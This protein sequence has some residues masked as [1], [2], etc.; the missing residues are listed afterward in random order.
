ME[1]NNVEFGIL[2][3]SE[4]FDNAADG[5][6]YKE[7][8]EYS[9]VLDVIELDRSRDADDEDEEDDNINHHDPVGYDELL[10]AIRAVVW[11][12]V[13]LKR[14][15]NGN[16]LRQLQNGNDIDRVANGAPAEVATASGP[17][18]SS[19]RPAAAQ[20][21]AGAVDESKLEADL[22][23]FELLLTEVMMFKDTTSNWSRNERLAYAEKF[24]CK[25]LRSHVLA[26]MRKRIWN[27]F[28]YF[29]DAFDDLL[30]G[31]TE[32]RSDSDSEGNDDGNVAK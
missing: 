27:I 14:T 10:Q 28:I 4:I 5:I 22:G 32:R 11:S 23:A 15:T 30:S 8:K 18:D 29:A 21:A 1:E 7:A 25:Y 13:D 6:T 2:L 9:N 17:S 3:C 24:A 20:G 12:N 19:S 26:V 31:G 16:V